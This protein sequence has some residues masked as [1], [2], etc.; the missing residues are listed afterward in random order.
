MGTPNVP[1]KWTGD[2]VKRM[3]LENIT[4]QQIADIMGVSKAY[5]TMILN[6]RKTPEDAKTRV[7]NA[8]N[9]IVAN[10]PPA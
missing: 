7:W 5:V 8:I 1:P 6:G 9:I 4:R 10:R 3:H 2:A